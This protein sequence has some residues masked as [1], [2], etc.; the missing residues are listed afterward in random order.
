MAEKMRGFLKG[1]KYGFF[2]G[3]KPGKATA[4]RISGL[5]GGSRV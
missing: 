2:P 4:G 3:E 5:M 1:E